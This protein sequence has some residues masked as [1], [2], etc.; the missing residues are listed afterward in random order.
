MFA[1]L[2]V[3]LSSF[4]S[5]LLNRLNY[6]REKK[7]CELKMFLINNYSQNKLNCLLA[8]IFD[9]PI[10]F[11]LY[12]QTLLTQFLICLIFC[13]VITNIGIVSI[14]SIDFNIN[15]T[16]IKS[17]RTLTTHKLVLFNV[18]CK[19]TNQLNYLHQ[20]QQILPLYFIKEMKLVKKN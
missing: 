4:Q 1:E 8:I 7:W 2:S 11:L 6:I 9:C 20:L 10:Q 5:Y 3:L 17:N 13:K 18:S 19:A 12:I 16:F 15:I 14:I